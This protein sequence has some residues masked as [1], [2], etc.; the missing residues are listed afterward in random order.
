MRD[1]ILVALFCAGYFETHLVVWLDNPLLNSSAKGAMV[2]VLK[3][4]PP[5][6]HFGT[7]LMTMFPVATG[8][9]HVLRFSCARGKAQAPV[10]T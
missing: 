1:V 7:V 8:P 3:H 9:K 4:P 2:W 6:A 5:R 10:Q